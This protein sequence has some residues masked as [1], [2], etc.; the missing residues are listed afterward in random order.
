MFL[1]AAGVTFKDKIP[2]DFHCILFS[3]VQYSCFVVIGRVK[4]CININFCDFNRML[5][6][7]A[8][9]FEYVITA[10]SSVSWSWNMLWAVG[11]L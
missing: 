7:C 3:Y 11:Q 6:I 8:P 2:S 9:N 1:W 4:C 10:L 5:Q